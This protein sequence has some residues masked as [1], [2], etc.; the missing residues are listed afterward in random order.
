M[1]LDGG[2]QDQQSTQEWSWSGSDRKA[3]LGAWGALWCNLLITV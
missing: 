3:P 1:F 2:R